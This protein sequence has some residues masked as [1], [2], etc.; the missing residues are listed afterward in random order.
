MKVRF[1]SMKERRLAHDLRVLADL[2]EMY[3]DRHHADRARSAFAS[4]AAAAGP[5]GRKRLTL[6]EECAD[7]LRYGQAR[8]ARCPMDPKPFCSHCT[9][10]C[11]RDSEAEWQR[12]VM[13]YSG[14]RS[15]RRGHLLDGLRHAI[16]TARRRRRVRRATGAEA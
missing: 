6:C 9:S 3:C 12:M 2:A 1:G 16:A 15:W 14:P 13:R 8:R 10:R 4:P 7:H 5:Y 11:Y